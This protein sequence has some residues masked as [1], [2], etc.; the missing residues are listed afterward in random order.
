MVAL[1]LPDA[2]DLTLL[3]DRLYTE[4]KIEVPLIAWNGRKLIRVSIQGYN[5]RRD[6]DKLLLAL[7]HLL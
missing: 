4:Y 7:K 6:L 2:V 5:T 1:P 3:K